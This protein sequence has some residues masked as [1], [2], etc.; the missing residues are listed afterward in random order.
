MG[1]LNTD[2]LADSN[3]TTFMKDL[4]NELSLQV[5]NHRAT[6]HPPGSSICKTWIGVMCVDSNDTV[7]NHFNE[8]PSFQTD[9]NLIVA[10]IRIFLPKIPKESFSYRKFNDITPEALNVHRTSLS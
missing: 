4:F 8:I 7:L 5:I 6:R 1:D 2:L 3:N 9:H 10:N